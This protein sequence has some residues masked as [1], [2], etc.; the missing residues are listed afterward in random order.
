VFF[1]VLNFSRFDLHYLFALQ[2]LYNDA[3][4]ILK[5]IFQNISQRYIACFF[6]N[7]TL[8]LVLGV[9]IKANCIF[10]LFHNVESRQYTEY[11]F[12]ADYLIKKIE[13]T[14]SKLVVLVNNFV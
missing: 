8:V 10:L 5:T 4:F 7:F 13:L 2:G 11:G 14:Y 12:S 3:S 9:L 1:L 6:R